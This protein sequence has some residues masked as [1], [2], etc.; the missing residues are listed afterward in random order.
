MREFQL[1]NIKAVFL[2]AFFN[3]VNDYKSD[4]GDTS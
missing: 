2:A 4:G 1:N 3:T